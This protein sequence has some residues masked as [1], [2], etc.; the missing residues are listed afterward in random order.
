MTRVLTTSLAEPMP[1]QRKP[2][3]R[4]YTVTWSIN[5]TARSVKHAARRAR[6]AQIDPD[7]IATV[8]AVEPG[9]SCGST[10]TLVDV[11]P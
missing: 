1:P 2:R 6:L 3:Y 4:D 8:F 10:G 7:T 9:L 11:K 5:T